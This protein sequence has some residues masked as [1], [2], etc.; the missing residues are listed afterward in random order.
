[1]RTASKTS[2]PSK[3]VRG[4]EL[5]GAVHLQDG[6]A[7]V[8]P[9]DQVDAGQVGARR[10]SRGDRELALLGCGL[11]RPPLRSQA[12]VRPPFAWSRDPANG[13]DDAPA[14]DEEPQVRS[15]RRDELLD[16]RSLAPKPGL[17]A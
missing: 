5:G 14:R 9:R 10:R 13:S 12:H 1:M 17:P 7:A 2:R 3:G 8:G 4:R 6:V 11:Q 16:Q 15:R